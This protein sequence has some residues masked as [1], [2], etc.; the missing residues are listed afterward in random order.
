[1]KES[2]KRKEMDFDETMQIQSSVTPDNTGQLTIPEQDDGDIPSALLLH[3]RMV[4]NWNLLH[5]FSSLC[6]S[7]RS[8]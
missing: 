6:K 1:M 2:E 8:Q 3:D 5:T 4:W 7:G